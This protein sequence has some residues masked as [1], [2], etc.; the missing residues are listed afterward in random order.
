MTLFLHRVFGSREDARRYGEPRL[1][2]GDAC[3]LKRGLIELTCGHRESG[4]RHKSISRRNIST[5]T[6]FMPAGLPLALDA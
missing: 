1:A 5:S 3:G 6:A 2:F 4:H